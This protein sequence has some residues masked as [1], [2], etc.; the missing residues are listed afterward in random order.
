MRESLKAVT[1]GDTYV[2]NIS[3]FKYRVM[4][5]DGDNVDIKSGWNGSIRTVSK[6]ILRTQFTPY[7]EP[8]KDSR[9]NRRR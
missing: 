9:N 5:V 2:S 8:V 1:K 3:N 4:S 7:S 6:F